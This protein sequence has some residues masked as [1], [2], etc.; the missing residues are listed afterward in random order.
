M[1]R[2]FCSVKLLSLIESGF[3]FLCDRVTVRFNKMIGHNVALIRQERPLLTPM[4]KFR[5]ELAAHGQQGNRVGEIDNAIRQIGDIATAKGNAECV[6][7]LFISDK[8]NSE[9]Y[10][11]MKYGL[12]Q[13]GIPVQVVTAKLIGNRSSL[14]IFSIISYM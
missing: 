12:L 5:V 1:A 11:R 9:A 13:R 7:P 6:L 2:W 14:M 10:Y 4:H 8:E 3:G